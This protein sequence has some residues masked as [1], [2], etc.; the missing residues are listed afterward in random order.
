[1]LIS[2]L[3]EMI[4]Y[5][6]NVEE[7]NTTVLFRIY[8]VVEFVALSYFFI[9][10]TRDKTVLLIMKIVVVLFCMVTLVDA[11]LQGIMSMDNYSI[12]IESIIFI[13]YCVYSMLMLMKE[14]AYQSILASSRFWII[15]AILVYFAGNLFVFVFSNYLLRKSP[16]VFNDL[17]GV[18]SILNI[19]FYSLIAIAF[20]KIKTPAK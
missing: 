4:S 18:H 11:I 19:L 8:T 9:Q 20:W 16:D 1:M 14:A 12:A 3:T 6:C 10:I 2:L 7:W 15:V 5:V 17:W 13:F